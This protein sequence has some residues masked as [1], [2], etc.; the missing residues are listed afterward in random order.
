[1]QLQAYVRHNMTAEY[2]NFTLTTEAGG[3]LTPV[4]ANTGEVNFLFATDPSAPRAVILS[5]KPFRK[6]IQLRGI[7]DSAGN[8]VLPGAWYV[9]TAVEP[10]IN[11]FGRVETYRHRAALANE[12]TFEAI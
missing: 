8:D 3:T 7:T 10:V 2:W 4:Y 6:G 9:I 5:K 12:P 1:M 11:M